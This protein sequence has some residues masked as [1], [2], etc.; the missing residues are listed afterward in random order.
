MRKLLI[1][2]TI[3]ATLAGCS[4]IQIDNDDWNLFGNTIPRS[5]EKLP[6]IHR[7]LIVQGNLIS[8]DQVNQLKIGMHKEQVRLVM[9]TPLLHD[10]FHDQRWDY[11]YG[12]GIGK[13]ELEKHLTLYFDDNDRLARIEGD[14]Q[15]LPAFRGKGAEMEKQAVVEVPDWTPPPKTLF[16]QLMSTVGVDKMAGVLKKVAG[17]EYDDIR[18]KAEQATSGS[19]DEQDGSDESSEED[20]SPGL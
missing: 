9:G 2:I 14:Y 4:K 17:D 1:F 10:V 11:Y 19:E 7:P 5:L 3:G 16:D 15:P 13:I 18:A 6:F 20:D 8:Q 12:L